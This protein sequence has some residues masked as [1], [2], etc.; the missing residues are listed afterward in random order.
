MGC[1]CSRKSRSSSAAKIKQAKKQNVKELLTKKNSTVP[2]HVASTIEIAEKQRKG[3]KNK[4]AALSVEVPVEPT[5][6]LLVVEAVDEA[7]SNGLFHKYHITNSNLGR[8]GVKVHSINFWDKLDLKKLN[9][10]T[11]SI[12]LEVVKHRLQCL[13][14]SE[15]LQDK[16]YGDA[17]KA[18][19]EAINSL[20]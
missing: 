15:K 2:T 17:L 8:P 10:I 19:I 20:G 11:E 7:D 12:L 1:G 4:K 3:K 6:P 13:Q 16:K 9:G 18:V 14:N 5:Q